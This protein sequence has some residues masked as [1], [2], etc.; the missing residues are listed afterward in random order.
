MFYAATG[1]FLLQKYL[2]FH[3]YYFWM[4]RE[5][6]EDNQLFSW[7]VCLVGSNYVYYELPVKGRLFAYI[8]KEKQFIFMCNWFLEHCTQFVIIS[9]SFVFYWL[10]IIS[11]NVKQ[12]FPSLFFTLKICGL[13]TVFLIK[14]RCKIHF[15]IYIFI[16][17]L[18]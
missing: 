3:L 1:E 6:K 7:Y 15:I 17:L 13:H 10:L 16:L 18:K 12:H 8:T 14:Q 5:F 9:Y 11:F 2:V 4:Y